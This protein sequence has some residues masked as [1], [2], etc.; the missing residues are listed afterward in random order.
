MRSFEAH[1]SAKTVLLILFVPLLSLIAGCQWHSQSQNYNVILISIDTLRAD[2]LSCYGYFRETSP[3]ID[4]FAENAL[5]Y[6]K[7]L[8]CV[9]VYASVPY[10]YFHVRSSNNTRT[11]VPRTLRPPEQENQDIAGNITGKRI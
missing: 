9:T 8:R 11:D 5:Q 6:L 1:A 3:T 4:A 10:V 2:H 7:R